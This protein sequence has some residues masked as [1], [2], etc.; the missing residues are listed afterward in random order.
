MSIAQSSDDGIDRQDVLKEQIEAEYV[1][2]DEDVSEEDE[3]LTWTIWP[4]VTCPC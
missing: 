2:P 1:R 4:C 3:E